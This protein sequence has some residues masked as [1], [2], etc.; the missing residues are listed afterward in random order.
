MRLTYSPQHEA[1]RQELRQYY[2]KLLSPEI[3]EEI[4]RSEGVGPV[5]RRVAR[6]MGTDGWLGIGWP[7]EYG[8]RGMT[9]IEQFIFFDESMRAGAPVPML[10]VNSVAPTIMQFGSD[11]QKNFYLP[12]IL[13]GEIHFAIGYTEPDAGTDLASLKTRAVRDGDSF[14]INGQKVFTSLATDA[15]YIW[16]AVRTDPEAP[17]HKGISMIIVPRETPGVRVVPIKNMGN[18]NTN[19]TFYDDVRV[20]VGNLVGKLNGGWKL[21]TNQLNHERVTLCSSGMIEGRFEEVV[22]WAKDTKLADGRRV[23]DQQ[24]VQ[25]NLARIHARLDFLRVMNF[26]VAWNAEQSQ[27][28][29]PAHASTIKVFGTEFYLEACRLMQEILGPTAA[30]RPGSPEAALNGRVGQF[31]RSIHILTFGGGTNEMQRDLICLFGLGMPVMPRF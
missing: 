4:A 5:A 19:Q 6:Q 7:K 17:K 8:G 18:F 24:W 2:K 15:D 1:L 14:V 28:L 23:I 22:R 21:I 29:Q 3:L 25:I 10:T 9:P 13:K 11:E 26:K 31:V 20:P 12:K 16:L 27:P 30:L